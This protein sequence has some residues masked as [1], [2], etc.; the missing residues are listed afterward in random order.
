[1]CTFI[2]SRFNQKVNFM[3]PALRSIVGVL[4]A[5]ACSTVVLAV[6]EV[7]LFNLVRDS[8]VII[9]AGNNAGSGFIC[10]LNGKKYLITNEHV[11]RGGQPLVAKLLNG[12]EL[13]F[14]SLEVADDRDLVR[15]EISDSTLKGLA[16]STKE[17]ALNEPVFVFG[18]SDGGGVATS[19]P[20]K[21]LGVG[22]VFIETD[23]TFVAGN[24][25]STIVNS[26][27]EVIAVATFAIR[28]AN[29]N[30]WVKQGSR[31][32]NVR[33]FGVKL[34]GTTWT[35]ITEKDY[36]IR[37]HALADIETFCLD[38]YKLR[39]TTFYI[40]TAALRYRYLYVNE[41][42]RYF[43]FP[44]L[45]KI[46]SDA[47][48]SFNKALDVE[49]DAIKRIQYAALNPHLIDAAT[50]RST[51]IMLDEQAKK[52]H[53]AAYKKVYTDVYTMVRQNN[54]LTT[55]MKKDAAFW[56]DVVKV[57]SEDEGNLVGNR[58]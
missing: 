31:F 30:D 10:Q 14:L 36:F 24:S 57:I 9:T 50:T 54:W 21:L 53:L 56:L 20:G 37:A 23:A 40:D 28:D 51:G 58:R 46:L 7:P 11:I 45:C 44:N 12:K 25:G 47:A 18:N 43:S 55:S 27:G 49:A 22:P 3:I 33:R 2:F 39:F 5:V 48:V 38:L 29:P 13:S 32:T 15:L 8:L 4:L 19:L 35:L 6:D 17:H 26:D 41:K 34:D 52:R 1:M 42:K 16:V